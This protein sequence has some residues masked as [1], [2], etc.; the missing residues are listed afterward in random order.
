MTVDFREAVGASCHTR[1]PSDAHTA[2]DWS[3]RLVDLSKSLHR[4]AQGAGTPRAH[5]KATDFGSDPRRSHIGINK[6][7]TLLI[8]VDVLATLRA[9]FPPSCTVAVFTMMPG[10]SSS[11]HG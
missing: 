7:T 1:R 5:S 3:R 8:G 2:L 6:R 9:A 10:L 11:A 4:R